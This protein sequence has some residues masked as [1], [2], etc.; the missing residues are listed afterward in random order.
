MGVDIET[1]F[2]L[3]KDAFNTKGICP[4]D[5]NDTECSLVKELRVLQNQLKEEPQLQMDKILTELQMLYDS[6][7][8]YRMRSLCWELIGFL[9]EEGHSDEIQMLCTLLKDIS[10]A[11]EHDKAVLAKRNLIKKQIVEIKKKLGIE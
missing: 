8:D 11:Q 4:A 1:I 9:S 3:V 10:E 5:N 2:D 6:S 7:T